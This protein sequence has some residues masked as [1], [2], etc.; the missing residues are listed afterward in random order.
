MFYV[1]YVAAAWELMI[2]MRSPNPSMFYV[3]CFICCLLLGLAVGH[4]DWLIFTSLFRQCLKVCLDLSTVKSLR[5]YN[6]VMMAFLSLLTE[7]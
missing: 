1:L 4:K 7:K 5:V 2:L 6:L 3:L